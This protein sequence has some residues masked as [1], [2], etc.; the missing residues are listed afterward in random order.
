LQLLEQCQ[1]FY[2]QRQLFFKDDAIGGN[3][4]FLAQFMAGTNH[5]TDFFKA[6]IPCKIAR[7]KAGGADIDGVGAAVES[8]PEGFH[9][10]GGGKEFDGRHQLSMMTSPSSPWALSIT[11]IRS[12]C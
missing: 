11:L 12:L 2:N 4:E 7:V 5:R 9:T 3:K 1:V 6:Q 10:S 8:R